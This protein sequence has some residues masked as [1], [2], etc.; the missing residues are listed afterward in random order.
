MQSEPPIATIPR[1]PRGTGWFILFFWVTQF[2]LLTA[3][4]IMMMPE[5]S[6]LPYILPR[7]C[8]TVLGI[9][10]SFGIAV[11]GRRLQGRPL[12]VRIALAFGLATLGA[13]LH[14]SGNLL[15]FNLF[16][17]KV[18]AEKFSILSYMIAS[19]QWFWAY[20]ALSALLLAFW[21][22]VE[23]AERERRIAQLRGIADAAQLRALR[24]QLNPHFMF[25]TLNSIAALIARRE[26]EPAEL[27]VENLAD[28]LRAC[29]SLDPQADIP[30]DRE[31]ELQALYLAIEAVRFADRLDVRIDIPFEAR[32]ALVPSLVLQPLIENVVK[33]AVSPSR[34]QVTLDISARI[35]GGRLHVCVRNSAGDGPGQG[36]RGTGVG[37]KNVA[38]RL[39]A[40]FGEDCAFRAEPLAEGGFI[41]GFAIPWSVGDGA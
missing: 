22:A 10:L 27:M 35:E 18:N 9:T 28:F 21:Y 7:L 38:E 40:R 19:V 2:S 34:T 3:Q 36:A 29:L 30:L 14:A 4:S 26:V 11:I 37:L 12:R 16:M 24:Y 31:I 32:G 33:H 8:V 5:D 41:V 20:L 6:N 13:F 23:S 25:N 17:P 39:Q 15:I 1:V